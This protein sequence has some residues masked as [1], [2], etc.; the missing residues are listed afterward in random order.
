MSLTSNLSD[1][2]TR[3]ATETKALR[4]LINGNAID[5]SGLTTTAKAN[6]VAAINELDAAVDNLASGGS[7]E[8]L[9][10]LTDVVLTTPGAGHILRH[11]GVSFVNVLGADHY[12]PLDQD[13]TDIAALTTTPYG[14][15]LLTLS[16]QAA[17]MTLI[18]SATVTT[19]GKVELATTTETTAGT[20]ASM[21][22]TPAGAKAA[23]DAAIAAL[24]DTAPTTMDTLNEIAAA[25]GDDPNF[26]TTITTALANR[27]RVDTATQGLT[28]IQQDNA[29]TNINAASATDVGDTSTNFVAVFEAGLV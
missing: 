11:D 29:R 28:A 2:F 12:Q 10:D 1:A 3:V 21:A 19:K 27:V 20:D 24:V 13:L 6:L 15:D 9:N 8:S 25:L 17:L 5:L 18:S 4:T 26:A 23:I 14:R 16:S 22:V 7:T